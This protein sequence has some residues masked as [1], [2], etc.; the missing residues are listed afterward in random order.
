MKNWATRVTTAVM[1]LAMT[2]V[3]AGAQG[4]GQGGPPPPPADPHDLTG[5]WE[6]PFD[7]RNVPRADL[8]AS[9]AAIDEAQK[10]TDNGIRWCNLQ[11]VPF[12]MGTSRPLNI[13]LGVREM[14]IVP[15]SAVAAP[16]HV[17]LDRTAHIDPKIWDA[18]TNGDSIGHWEGD[19]LVVDT[20]GFHA[21][22][23]NLMIPGGG[24][25][26]ADSHLVERYKLMNNGQVLSVTF[27]WTDPNVFKTP[28]TYE[29]RYFR[30]QKTYEPRV[31]L[32]CNAFDKDRV[33]FVTDAATHH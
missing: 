2:A 5:Y 9:K 31:A 29:F 13:E 19:T 32:A 18:T 12:L 17:Y 3:T 22:H 27:T 30:L 11:G 6:L 4:R 20:A 1:V 26:T 33:A 8:V 10:K 7:G 14:V 21:D 23:G 28:H 15:E 25:K 16:R 24:F